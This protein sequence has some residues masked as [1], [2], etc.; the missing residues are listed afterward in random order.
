MPKAVRLPI[1]RTAQSQPIIPA[2]AKPL[3]LEPVQA[4]VADPT[5]ITS[6]PTPAPTETTAPTDAEALAPTATNPLE[7]FPHFPGAKAGC[8]DIP[9][10]FQTGNPLAKVAAYFEKELPAK[11]Y[12]QRLEIDETERKVYQFSRA[13]LTQ[14]LSLIEIE[15]TG[16]VYVLADAPRTLDELKKAVEVPVELGNVLAQLVPETGAA[17][18]NGEDFADSINA[19]PKDFTEP[20]RFYE[21]LGGVD[22]EGFEI[23]PTPNSEIYGDL[24]V[25]RGQTP[26]Q[27]LVSTITPTLQGNGFTISANSS[28]EYGGGLLYQIQKGKFTGYLNLV[29]TKDGTG[30]IVTVW[31]SSPM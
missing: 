6:S 5:P 14:Y 4:V 21:S 10:C 22:A 25:V 11:Q 31:T 13:G 16:T 17:G 29:P 27:I 3:P 20:E 24:K 1:A 8:L 15:G 26:E 23:T 7:D 2:I 30:T 12:E 9:S 28:G 18:I 19:T